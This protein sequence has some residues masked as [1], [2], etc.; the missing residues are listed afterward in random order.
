MNE[1]TSITEN[2][3]AN[4][5]LVSEHLSGHAGFTLGY[6]EQSIEWLEGFIERQR[7]REDFNIEE[8]A[9]LSNMLGCFVGECLCTEF[10]GE[11]QQ[12]EYGLGVVF[13]NGNAAFPF[14]KVKKQFANGNEAGDSILGF[15]QSIS[16]IS[17]LPIT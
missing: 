7:D 10:K 6:D 2:I 1:G 8:N 11:W 17:T 9:G 12:T 15:Y 4:A 16:A 14:A 13:P 5:K 3:R